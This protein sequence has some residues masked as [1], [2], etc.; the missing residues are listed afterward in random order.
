MLLD[1]FSLVYIRILFMNFA[2]W[3]RLNDIGEK[4]E[5]ICIYNYFKKQL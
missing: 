4:T 3:L 5:S 1:S 2:I